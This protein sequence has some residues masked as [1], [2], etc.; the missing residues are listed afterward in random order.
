M[1]CNLDLGNPGF[2]FLKLLLE[3]CGRR[4]HPPLSLICHFLGLSPHVC[5]LILGFVSKFRHSL[6]DLNIM[7]LVTVTPESLVT[8]ASGSVASAVLLVAAFCTASRFA[9]R[10]AF[11]E[12]VL[13]RPSNTFWLA[14][15]PVAFCVASSAETPAVFFERTLWLA[16]IS[17]L[18][19]VATLLG[20]W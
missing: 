14:S 1:V 7:S 13:G 3:P 9:N 8:A 6:Q 11:S 12:A 15:R 19:W 20:G 2:K 16:S 4:Q 5:E 17:I 10:L 18:C